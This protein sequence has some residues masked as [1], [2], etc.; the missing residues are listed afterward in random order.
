VRYVELKL[1]IH[2]LGTSEIYFTSCEKGII[3]PLLKHFT[4]SKLLNCSV[5]N[6]V[7]STLQAAVESEG[8]VCN[9]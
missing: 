9:N 1:H 6:A 2:T 3:P 5:Y 4:D 8:S 7:S